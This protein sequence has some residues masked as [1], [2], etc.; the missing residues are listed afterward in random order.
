MNYV[1][2]FT[3]VRSDAGGKIGSFQVAAGTRGA[4]ARVS[5]PLKRAAPVATLSPARPEEHSA[6]FSYINVHDCARRRFFSAPSA[7]AHSSRFPFP[8]RF[9]PLSAYISHTP[10]LL[11]E[12]TGAIFHVHIIIVGPNNTAPRNVSRKLRS[13][14]NNIHPPILENIL[15]APPPLPRFKN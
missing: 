8:H 7:R 9:R 13:H 3:F 12:Q 4:V 6:L 1:W 5:G 15:A 14:S 10:L 2:N 11:S